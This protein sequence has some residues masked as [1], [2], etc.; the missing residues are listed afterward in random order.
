M[1]SVSASA[2]VVDVP[3]P[4]GLLIFAPAVLGLAA[5]R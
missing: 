5:L 3:D 4:V 1:F 2:F